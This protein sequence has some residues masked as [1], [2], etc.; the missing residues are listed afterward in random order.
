MTQNCY[1]KSLGAI[2]QLDPQSM[3]VS[4]DVV[5][6]CSRIMAPMC[7]STKHSRMCQEYPEIK[8]LCQKCSA[9]E[10]RSQK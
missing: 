9:A 10:T 6:I 2:I 5:C 7:S 1:D 8:Y 4:M 3:Y